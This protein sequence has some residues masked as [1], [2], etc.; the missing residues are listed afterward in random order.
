MPDKAI[1]EKLINNT[2]FALVLIGIF[3]FITGASGGWPSLSLTVSQLG[4]QIALAVMG[5]IV[6]GTG[7]LLLWRENTEKLS[8][9]ISTPSKYGV[10]IVSPN[11]MQIQEVRNP[12]DISGKYRNLKNVSIQCFAV[13]N[14]EYWPVL[15]PGS[16][17]INQGNWH[18]KLSFGGDTGPRTII[19]AVSG[20]SG[21][22]LC[23]YYWKVGEETGEWPSI[24]TLA[25]DIVECDRVTVFYRK[26]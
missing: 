11:K 8:D 15:K 5:V 19:S 18:A 22:A 1:I 21:L 3:L 7:G 9:K 14:G 6:A 25:P 26:E 20:K 17:I 16:L 4:W 10:E 24:R 2:P 12:M 13:Y 23:E